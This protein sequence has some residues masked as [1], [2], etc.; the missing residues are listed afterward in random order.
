MVWVHD[1]QENFEILK[2]SGGCCSQG[3][4][5][6]PS[7]IACGPLLLLQAPSPPP[8]IVDGFKALKYDFQCSGGQKSMFL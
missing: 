5:G 8:S 3:C 4:H 2:P 1:A 7:K 6:L